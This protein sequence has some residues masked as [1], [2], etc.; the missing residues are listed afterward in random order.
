MG[1]TNKSCVDQTNSS[2]RDLLNIAT[3]SDGVLKDS[4]YAYDSATCS[5]NCASLGK[6]QEGRVAN[7]TELWLHGRGNTVLGSWAGCA[8]WWCV[9]SSSALLWVPSAQVNPTSCSSAHGATLP[10]Y[11]QLKCTFFPFPDGAGPP[12]SLS[13]KLFVPYP[14]ILDSRY[15]LLFSF[16]FPR[17][18]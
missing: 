6:K 18:S 14:G 5:T 1:R 9:V 8:M 17:Y 7:R 12:F 13:T 2:M 10:S 16:S 11:L 3:R 4:H 15:F